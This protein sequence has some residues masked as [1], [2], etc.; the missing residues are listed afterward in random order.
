M[1]QQQVILKE[2]IFV[3]GVG[4]IDV[5]KSS[6]R[7]F[8]YDGQSNTYELIDGRWKKVCCPKEDAIRGQSEG[9]R[10]MSKRHSRQVR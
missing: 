8:A 7:K 4:V 1:P 6:D 10:P 5:N 2:Q 3:Q 9:S